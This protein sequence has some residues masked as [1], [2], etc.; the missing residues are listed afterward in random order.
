MQMLDGFINIAKDEKRVMHMWNSFVSRQR[1]GPSPIFL[2]ISTIT[3]KEVFLLPA[4]D[5]LARIIFTPMACF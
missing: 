1:S 4:V 5:G 3:V 2:L